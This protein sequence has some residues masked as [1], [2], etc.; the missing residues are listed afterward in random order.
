MKRPL[1]TLI[2]DRRGVS[3][4]EFA[5]LAPLMIAFYFGLAEFCQGFMAQKRVGH[6]ASV[7]AD[8]VS[9]VDEIDA[10]E[11]ADIFSVG[12]L[13]MRPFPSDPLRQRVSSVRMRA[14]GRAEVVWSR[15]A[16]MAAR[17]AGSAVD[18]PAGLLADGESLIMAEASYDYDSPVDYLL[19]ALTRF[20]QVYYLRPRRVDHI[21]FR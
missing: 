16:G 21:S 8:L 6:I 4:V 7:V 17:G 5:L 15:G 11:M 19:P 14:N 20:E 3:A 2:R 18:L 13:V 1:L 12:D 9:Q 10:G